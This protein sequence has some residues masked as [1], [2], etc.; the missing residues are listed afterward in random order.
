[1]KIRLKRGRKAPKRDVRK[2][3]QAIRGGGGLTKET[4]TILKEKA[5]VLR[6][7]TKV[8]CGKKAGGAK[9]ECINCQRG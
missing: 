9:R 6:K 3:A 1:M 5:A 2:K 7:K 8:F 4:T